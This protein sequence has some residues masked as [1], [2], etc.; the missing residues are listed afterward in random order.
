MI[1]F[2]IGFHARAEQGRWRRE[3]VVRVPKQHGAKSMDAGLL[4][5]GML[6][7]LPPEPGARAVGHGACG[8]VVAVAAWQPLAGDDI[9]RVTLAHEPCGRLVGRGQGGPW[10]LLRLDDL[11]DGQLAAFEAAAARAPVAA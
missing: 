11:T 9:W 2:D 7:P 10:R 6:S 3:R 1:R 4:G 5:T 8:A